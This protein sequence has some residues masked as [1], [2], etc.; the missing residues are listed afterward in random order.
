MENGESG[1]RESAQGAQEQ[2][3]KTGSLIKFIDL[4]FNVN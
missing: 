3:K 1:L 4:G 2:V